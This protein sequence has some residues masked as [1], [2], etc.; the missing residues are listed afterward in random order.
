MG[1]VGFTLR[2]SASRG[3]S[4]I[5]FIIRGTVRQKA[6]RQGILATAVRTFTMVVPVITVPAR[7]LLIISS[8]LTGAP[9]LVIAIKS[10]VV[11]ITGIIKLLRHDLAAVAVPAVTTVITVIETPVVDAAITIFA[12]VAGPSAPGEED[13]QQDCGHHG[14]NDFFH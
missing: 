6:L 3:E 14:C 2:L 10:V 9:P 8:A 4:F 1:L 13:R 5:I 12:A 11:K 7:S